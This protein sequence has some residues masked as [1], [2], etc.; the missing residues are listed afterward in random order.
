MATSH[1]TADTGVRTPPG[2]APA[3]VPLVDG[4][5]RRRPHTPSVQ[6][7][8]G[9][10]VLAN[11]VAVVLLLAGGVWAAVEAAEDESLADARRTTDLLAAVLVEPNLSPP[12]LA[13]DPRALADFDARIQNRIPKADVIR[14]KIWNVDG[15]ILYSDEPRLIGQRYALDEEDQEALRD[16]VTRAEISDLSRPENRFERSAGQLLEVYRQIDG[17][18]GESLLLETYSVY[19]EATS[20]QFEI[21]SEFAPIS[22]AVV[23]TLL[24]VQLPLAHRM[25]T[26]LRAAQR[27]R[28]LLQARAL[29]ASTEE[30][31]R[32]AGSL[33]DGI[34]Q[35]VS[36]SALLVARAA[37]Q[38]RSAPADGAAGQVAEGLGQA[39]AA[40]RESVGSLRSLLVEIYPPD[41]DRDDLPMALADLAGRLR[42]RGVDVR[43]TVAEDVEPSPAT[44]AL[45]LR[46]VQEALRNI[47]KH[48]RART[49]DVTVERAGSGLVLTVIDDGVGFDL[50]PKVEEPTR[51]HLGLRL[52]ADLA[53]TDG[54]TLSVRSAPGAGTG[55]RLEVPHP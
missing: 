33:H 36:A 26:Q 31:R 39:A 50:G 29:D 16:G 3:W 15:E 47:A 35:D 11:V 43:V 41:L 28:E 23:L 53:A 40:L 54:A 8:V 6:R 42:P 46:T 12:L 10:F 27:E 9:R 34:V 20:R 17:P 30:R 4:A 18:S 52:L 51:G 7:V 45:V 48:S 44:A 38:V 5:A 1:R 24:A 13:G 55:L 21:W 22:V 37:D 32:I 14:L 25:L 2:A 49:V 19:Q